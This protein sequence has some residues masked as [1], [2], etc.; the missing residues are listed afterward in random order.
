MTRHIVVLSGAG[1]SAE[2]GLRTF[3]DNGGLWEDHRVEDVATPEAWRRNRAL[4]L[5]FYNERRKALLAAEPNRG[6]RIIAGWERDHDVTVVTQNVDDLHERAGSRRVLHLHG[7]LM[8]ARSTRDPEL[9]VPV[10]GGELKEGDLCPRGSQL[11]P[12]IVWFGEEVPL[13]P[14]A[15]AE[16]RRADVLVIVGTS[17]QVYPAAALAFEAPESSVRILI[18][19][20]PP[21]L[22]GAGITVIASGASEGL[23]EADRMLG[24]LDLAGSE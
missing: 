14:F 24:E 6:H 4:V 9:V 11:R 19:P 2:S 5:R 3:R 21:R 23:A 20:D 18:D 22:A 1:M 8:M 7:E 10:A 12:H 17:L 15:Q 13:M 16:V